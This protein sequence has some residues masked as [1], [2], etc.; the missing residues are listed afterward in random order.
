MKITLAYIEEPPFG[1]TAADGSA[2]G[3]DI[4][5]AT[6]VLRAMGA[7]HIMP[8]LTTFAE[9][10]PGVAAGRW[11]LNVPLFVTPERMAAVDFS[12]PV[13][14]IGDGLLVRA[15]NPMALTSYH[16][17]AACASGSRAK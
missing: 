9:L 5:L 12:L 1:W 7:T 10:L 15:G 4:E 8:R 3:A 6:V 13:W 14:A 17:V 11:D 16:A 2:T